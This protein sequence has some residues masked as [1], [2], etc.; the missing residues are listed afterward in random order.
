MAESATEFVD[1]R[2]LPPC[3]PMER[4]LA[5]LE[6]LPA[7]ARLRAV[8]DRDPVFLYPILDERGWRW[9]GVLLTPDRCEILI[10]RGAQ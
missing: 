4:I 3:Q 5:C 1:V 7:G 9:R 6:T 2:G 10:W 8:L